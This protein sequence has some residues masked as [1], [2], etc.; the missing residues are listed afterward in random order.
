[1]KMDIFLEMLDRSTACS[2]EFF[3]RI[4]LPSVCFSHS[5]DYAF[6]CIIMRIATIMIDLFFF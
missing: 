2:V 6:A 1:M 5:L 3:I 4:F